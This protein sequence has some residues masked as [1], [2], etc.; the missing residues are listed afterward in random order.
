M[1]S[2][3]Y[4]LSIILFSLSITDSFGQAVS[5]N[6]T[7]NAP[8]T[9][10]IL[11][12]TSSDKGVLLPRMTTAQRDAINP[13]VA[14]DLGMIIFNTSNS[15]YEYWDG[16]TWIAVGTGNANSL[17][18]A[19]DGGGS[20]LGRA[21]T[22]DAGTVEITTSSTVPGSLLLVSNGNNALS[23]GGNTLGMKIDVQAVSEDG[24]HVQHTSTG[25]SQ[26]Y[27]SIRGQLDNGSA[28]GYLGYH[29]TSNGGQNYAVY[30]AGG[31]YAGYFDGNVNLTGELQI[32]G[33]AGT[34]G[35]V[36]VSQGT[37]SDP[38]WGAAGVQS[39]TAGAGLGN[40]G[41]AT[42]L[43]LNAL[44]NN[45]LN[46][47][48][49]ADRIQLGGPLT[50]AT[51]IELDAFDLT[52]NLSSS[53][54][55]VIQ[56]GGVPHFQ[57]DNNDGNAFLGADLTI[58]DGSTIGTTLID[59]ADAGGGGNDGRIQVYSDGSINHT[60]HGD[61]NSVFNALNLNRDFIIESVNDGNLFYLDASADAIG[62]GVTAP[63]AQL[64]T[65]GTLRFANYANGFLQVDGSGNVSVA[66]GSSLFTAGTGLSW[67]GTTLN[68]VWTQNGNEIYNNNSA[69]VGIGT[70]SPN[71]L[72]QLKTNNTGLNVPLLIWNQ[73]LGGTTNNNSVGIGFVNEPNDLGNYKAAIV[74]ERLTNFGVGSLH[75][76]VDNVA[77]ANSATLSET[78]MTIT[79]SGNTGIGDTTPDAKLDVD[80]ASG[81]L[82]ILAQSG[83]QR[84]LV[85]IN[86]NMTISGK[87][88]SNGIEELSDARYKKNIQPLESVLEKVLQ[89]EGVTYNWR[90]E[91]FPERSFGTQT[92]IGF[93]AQELE[94]QFPELVSNSS[95]GYKSVQYSHMV[96]VLLE[97]IKE[98][99]E[100]ISILEKS[101]KDVTSQ[102]NEMT[103]ESN[104]LKSKFAVLTSE[105]SRLSMNLKSPEEKAEEEQLLKEKMQQ[106]GGNR[107]I[108]PNK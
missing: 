84:A 4:L 96:P 6:S 44:A 78:R 30:G 33:S 51:T 56:D 49:T 13:T 92:E 34:S 74:H 89:V 98:Q 87:F 15:V 42:A 61:G 29:T 39:V 73:Q 24:L 95:N 48:G 54:N 19:Y 65:D 68:N 70:D 60:I 100:K 27:F 36:L 46:I 1:K 3:F 91:E 16:S 31:S 10:S 47:D 21:I 103:I 71:S 37:G 22:A 83:T 55:F 82:L 88:N 108:N 93:I 86:G 45:G 75:F 20:G 57:I 17:D 32:N 40:T 7:G 14:S 67:S 26:A 2:N 25:N 62:I 85:D 43:I 53:G 76:L 9:Q 94:K 101:Y 69:N 107:V 104:E 79:S 97:A 28:D 63:T 50:E 35:Q 81:N 12:I 38:I 5:I 80:A 59:F 90:V 41:T 102:M 77:D 66:S 72:L 106:V 11:D 105:I 8:D 58:R 18:D 23:I 64:H 99:Q 52:F